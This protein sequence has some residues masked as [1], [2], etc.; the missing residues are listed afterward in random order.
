ML[1]QSIARA[2]SLGNV[3]LQP[4]VVAAE[5]ITYFVRTIFQ[6][7]DSSCDYVS[8]F[9]LALSVL[10]GGHGALCLPQRDSCMLQG[11]GRVLCVERAISEIGAEELGSGGK[12]I[13]R[14]T[15]P[16]F[17]DIRHGLVQ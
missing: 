10:E 3:L 7:R 1:R 14:I 13:C 15:V 12:G 9:D 17:H 4:A 5:V 6:V 16:I 8:V 11:V 2:S